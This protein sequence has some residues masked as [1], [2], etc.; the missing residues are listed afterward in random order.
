MERHKNLKPQVADP[1]ALSLA[2]PLRTSAVGTVRVVKAVLSPRAVNSVS[3][4]DQ[5]LEPRD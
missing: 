3:L 2:L 5:I 4:H 1:L